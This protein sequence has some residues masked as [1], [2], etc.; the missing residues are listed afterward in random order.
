MTDNVRSL[1]DTEIDSVAGGFF[2]LLLSALSACTSEY[3]LHAIESDGNQTQQTEGG[4]DSGNTGDT[5]NDTGAD[6]G[7]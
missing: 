6:T 7:K 2:S 5:G 3:G 1:T 4:S